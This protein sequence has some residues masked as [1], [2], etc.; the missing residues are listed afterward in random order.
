MG[1]IVDHGGNCFC[2]VEMHRRLEST[3]RQ[4]ITVQAPHSDLGKFGK[5]TGAASGA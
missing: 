5:Q 4:Q 3:V 2:A 1:P